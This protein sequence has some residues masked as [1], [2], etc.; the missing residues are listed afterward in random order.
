MITPTFNVGV[1][2]SPCLYRKVIYP[3]YVR[4]TDPDMVFVQI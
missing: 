1:I 4:K 2:I 3:I